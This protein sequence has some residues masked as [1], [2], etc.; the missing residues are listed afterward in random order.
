MQDNYYKIDILLYNKEYKSYVVVELKLDKL[1]Y[2]D[3]GQILLYVNYIYINIK[4]IDDNKTIGIIL[5]HR[6]N[7]FILEYCTD[8]RVVV[9][10]YVLN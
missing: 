1:K 6:N 5:C 4:S 2:K 3:I 10:E 9:R 8:S 7:R